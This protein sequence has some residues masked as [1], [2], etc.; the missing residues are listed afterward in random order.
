MT[1]RDQKDNMFSDYCQQVILILLIRIL[2]LTSVLSSLITGCHFT[3]ERGTLFPDWLQNLT[4]FFE[5]NKEFSM[6]L[7]K[8]WNF[9]VVSD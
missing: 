2:Q 6:I 9:N 1:D 4:D 5:E 7:G 3:R 8:I